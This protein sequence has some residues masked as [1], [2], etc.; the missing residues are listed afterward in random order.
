MVV[1]RVVVQAAVVAAEAEQFSR[2]SIMLPKRIPPA[3]LFLGI[4][5][6][7][8]IIIIQI[9]IFSLVLSRLGLSPASA[10]LLLVITLFGSAL[11]LPLFRGSSSFHNDEQN[12]L[13]KSL[14]PY[15]FVDGQTL[16]AI[17]VGG[18]LIPILFSTYLSISTDINLLVVLVAIT[19]VSTIS[20]LFS[21]PIANLGIGMPLFVAPVS[22]AFTAMLLSKENAPALAYICGS[23]GVVIG[24]DV[25]RIKDIKQLNA[26]IASIGGAG[27]FDGIFMTGIIAVLLTY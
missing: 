18:G 17:N 25:L 5:L 3:F 20:Y 12:P 11:N 6:V 10:S 7:V 27:T 2:A 26:P 13:H 4:L 8:V 21:R 23:L 1:H 9:E 15:R 24:A 22:A 16:I 14:L 19:V